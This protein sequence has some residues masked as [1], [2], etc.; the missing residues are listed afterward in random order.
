[1]KAALLAVLCLPMFAFAT[2]KV[3]LAI[4]YFQRSTADQRWEQNFGYGGS[5]GYGDIPEKQQSLFYGSW[6][7]QDGHCI[8]YTGMA[9]E[10][11]E[12]R[13]SW[14][15]AERLDSIGNDCSA[16]GIKVQTMSR[17]QKVLDRGES[18]NSITTFPDRSQILSH[19]LFTPY[20]K[21]GGDILKF[22]ADYCRNYRP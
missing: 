18:F 8:D 7:A 17:V 2:P 12:V 4:C 16:H 15:I 19:I 9:G 14:Y 11:L 3:N 10:P 5:S 22:V 21:L 1:M 13:I 20:D 6:S